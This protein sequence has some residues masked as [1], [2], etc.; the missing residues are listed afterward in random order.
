[1]ANIVVA[2]TTSSA[3]KTG[4]IVGLA[5]TLDKK[6][7]Y[8]KPLGD[9]LLYRK[10]RLWDFD[11]AVVTAAMG[12]GNAVE[13]LSI[14]FDQGKLRFTYSQEQ[15][16][17]RLRELVAT[18]GEGRDHLLIESGSQLRHG[19]SVHLNPVQIARA[20]GGK[21]LVVAG[22][23]DD[24]VVD[25]IMYLRRYVD[26]QG[27]EL[28][29]VIANKVSDP[30]DFELTHLPELLK[31]GVRVLGVL[32]YKSELTTTSVRFLADRLFAKVIAG[33]EH[34]DQVVRRYFVGASSA[35]AV[36]RDPAFKEAGKLII[37]S[38][39]R[40][41][42]I[43]ASLVSSTAGIVLTNNILPP[44]NIVAKAQENHVPLLM[45]P[46]DTFAVAKL[47]DDMEPLITSA[48]TE[49]HRLLAEMV[50]ERLDLSVF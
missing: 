19:T 15:M 6:L 27:V 24:A 35:D 1:M 47:I 30:E 11:S 3:G 49:K 25:D 38:G 23:G 16:E 36:L 10:K 41:D 8:I 7:G 29:G 12:N 18:V 21:L 31:L 43:L 48:D 26:T 42:L 44:S 50:A 45:V 40:S 28:L 9:R 2:S 5:L 37:T 33:E 20:V 46:G 4:L 14:G 22:G 39:D 17:A 34:M 13:G 32:P